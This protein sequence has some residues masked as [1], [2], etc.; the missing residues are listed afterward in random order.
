MKSFDL[1]F[2]VVAN[3]PPELPTGGY[4]LHF[5]DRSFEGETATQI[6]WFPYSGHG[7][8]ISFQTTTPWTDGDIGYQ[9]TARDLTLR[10][11]FDYIPPDPQLV[12]PTVDALAAIPLAGESTAPSDGEIDRSASPGT[13]QIPRTAGPVQEGAGEEELGEE[14]EIG[15]VM[16]RLAK[17]EIAGWE[18]ILSLLLAVVYG[19]GHALGP[20]H[21]K[22]MVAAYLVGSKGRIRDAITLGAVVTFAHTFSIF[23]LGLLLLYLIEQAADR[24]SGATY[25]NWITTSFSLLSGLLL[26]TFGLV[27][28][29]RRLRVARG[30]ADPHDHHHHGGLF[31][32]SH[33]HLG[34]A[35]GHSHDHS[36][37]HSHAPGDQGHSHDHDHDHSDGQDHGHTHEAEEGAGH[38]HDHGHAHDHEDPQPGAADGVRFRDL[39]TLGLSG[40]I[41]PCPA[42]FTI[43]LVAAHYQRLSLGLLYLT[44]FSLGLGAVLCAIGV[45]LV[46][47]K[48]GVLNLF[49][50]KSDLL[51]RWLPV[52]SACLVGAIGVYFVWDSVSQGRTEISQMLTALA[53][54]IGG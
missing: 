28:F 41:V 16:S 29:R 10:F 21:G 33:P 34:G 15:G 37:G 39:V 17:G 11:A 49:G 2:T 4:W 46:V 5:V 25:Q 22:S 6:S 35:H 54:Q 8:G 30:R 40:G 13:S 47:A 36:H 51:L 23:L 32:H 48:D 14:E 20:G 18:L 38:S 44:F 31:G 1:Y 45:V 27:L 19:A 9:R 26:F 50:S 24:A 7:E 3:M 42:G 43:M 53:R 12:A 52:G